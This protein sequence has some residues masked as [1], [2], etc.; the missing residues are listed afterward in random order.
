MNVEFVSVREAAVST[1]QTE[2]KVRALIHQG[3]LKIIRVGYHILIPRNELGKL[4]LGKLS[5]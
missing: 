1:G 4:Q 2:N 3:K 5:Q